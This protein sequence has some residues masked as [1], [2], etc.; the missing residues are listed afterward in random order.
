[1]RILPNLLI[2]LALIYSCA[3]KTENKDSFG[4]EI[5]DDGGEFVEYN[6]PPAEGFNLEGSDMLAMLLADK[7]MLAMGGREAWDNTRYIGWNFLGRRSHLWDK[8]TGDVRIEDLSNEITILMNIKSKEGSAFKGGALVT[9]SVDHLLQKGYEWWVN[10]SYWLVMPFKLKDSGVTLRYF[11]EGTTEDGK[12]ADII[13]LTFEGVGVTPQNIY[14]VWLD[15]DS[16]LVT[17]WAYY[18]DSAATE[19]RFV[20]P[21]NVYQQYGEIL[22]SGNRGDYNLK[23]IAVYNEVPASIFSDYEVSLSSLR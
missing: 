13:Q 19:P 7:C 16:K 15:T 17:Q 22:L 6:N 21:W 12:A 9:D 18:P 3:P 8:S 1:M 11:G 2:L 20:T 23:E 10:D 14:E 5:E 4:E